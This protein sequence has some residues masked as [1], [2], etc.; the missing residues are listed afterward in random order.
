MFIGINY[1]YEGGPTWPE[2]VAGDEERGCHGCFW[3]NPDKWR[4]SLNALIDQ[5]QR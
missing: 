4:Q 2:G 3:Y 1:F 5:H